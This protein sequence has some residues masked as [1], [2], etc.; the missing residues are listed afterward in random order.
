MLAQ[1]VESR[2]GTIACAPA[3]RDI[4]YW[5]TVAGGPVETL[6]TRQHFDVLGR[7][8]QARESKDFNDDVCLS[9]E[10]IIDSPY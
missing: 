5:R 7:D 1:Q 3:A 10:D 8:C 4:A 6:I 2:A 9:T